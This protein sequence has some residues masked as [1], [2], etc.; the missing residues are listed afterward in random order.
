MPP[1]L[2]DL[3]MSVVVGSFSFALLTKTKFLNKTIVEILSVCIALIYF[4][5]VQYILKDDCRDA[6]DRLRKGWRLFLTYVFLAF[7]SLFTFFRGTVHA[8]TK[9]F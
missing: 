4:N 9:L 7:Y 1:F 8:V 5:Q 2:V 3:P 6:C